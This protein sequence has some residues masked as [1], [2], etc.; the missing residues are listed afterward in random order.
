MSQFSF[1][2]EIKSMI[3]ELKNEKQW[4][5]LESI[6]DENNSISYTH[7][8][9]KLGYSLE[10]KG[11]LN[12]HI[13]SLER[14]GWLQNKVKTGHLVSDKHSSYYNVSKFGLK[15]LEGAV[16]AM[17]RKNYLV[18]SMSF[19]GK[20][21]LSTKMISDFPNFAKQKQDA[22]DIKRNIPEVNSLKIFKLTE[23]G[24]QGNNPERKKIEI[25]N[26]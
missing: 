2:D 21:E 23:S 5:I 8:R 20:N 12:Y 7:L 4:I 17:D 16:Q 6:I 3:T 25:T 18:D 14:S 9:E 10:K 24:F 26:G 22:L 13:K 15:V 11:D 1:P 19:F